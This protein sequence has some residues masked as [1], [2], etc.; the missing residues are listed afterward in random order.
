M[1][2]AQL[3]KKL[4]TERGYTQTQLCEGISSRTTLSSF[5]NRGT[6]L[7]SGILFQYLDRMN[8]RVEEYQLL[9]ENHEVSPK[10]RLAA[11]FVKEYYAGAFSPTLKAEIWENYLNSHDFYYYILWFETKTILA[12]KNNYFDDKKYE[13]EIN[14]ICDYLFKV[15][16][17]QH[18]EMTTFMN[19]MFA[20]S[21]EMIL[22]L[23]DSSK[24]TL[25]ENATNPYYTSLVT[26]FFI[27]GIILGFQRKNDHI[28]SQFLTGLQ[29]VAK[30][31]KY[32][33][34][35]MM[36]LY[37]EKL[38]QARN[39]TN[40]KDIDFTDFYAALELFGMSEKAQ[41]LKEFYEEIINENK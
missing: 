1:E 3:I 29:A 31:P 20:F 38:L 24:E 36:A 26:T 16:V 23:F 34:A 4:R 39:A 10:R 8:L 18:F 9:L 5:E 12:Y 37:F 11:Q 25:T 15:E 17:W 33:Y 30:K 7:S 13:K 21:D 27:N 14:K 40:P 41:E 2:Q 32:M 6:E 19:L 28:L 22:A 35:K